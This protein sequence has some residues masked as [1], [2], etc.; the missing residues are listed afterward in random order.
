MV[1]VGVN[2]L[3]NRLTPRNLVAKAAKPNGYNKRDDGL[4]TLAH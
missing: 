4:P 2:E 1:F 3:D